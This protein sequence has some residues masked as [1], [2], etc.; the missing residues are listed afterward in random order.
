MMKILIAVT[1]LLTTGCQTWSKADYTMAGLGVAATTVDL[2]QTTQSIVPHCD[3]TDPLIGSCGQNL[4]PYVVLPVSAA[5]VIGVAAA[6]PPK[7]RHY[8][9][10]AW[11]GVEGATIWLNHESGY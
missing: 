4:S 5:L 7:Y 10:G 1:I 9:L 8:L 6:L 2:Y 3:E 11:A